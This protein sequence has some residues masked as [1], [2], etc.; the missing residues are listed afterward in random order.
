[1]IPAIENIPETGGKGYTYIDRET[2]LAAFAEKESEINLKVDDEVSL[3]R[4]ARDKDDGRI[5]F[6]KLDVYILHIDSSIMLFQYEYQNDVAFKT[7]R[8]DGYGIDWSYIR[9]N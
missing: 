8:L 4:V 6:L 3:Y 5:V 9:T 1:M 2:F 7:M